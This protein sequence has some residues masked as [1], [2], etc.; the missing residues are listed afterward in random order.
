M[1]SPAMTTG[2]MSDTAKVTARWDQITPDMPAEQ[3]AEKI[4]KSVEDKYPRKGE[5]PQPPFGKRLP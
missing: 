4:D 5:M 2:G 3:A 1:A